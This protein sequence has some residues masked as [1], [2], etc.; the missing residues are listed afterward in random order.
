ME[1]PCLNDKEGIE[2]L[3]NFL[4]EKSYISDYEAT[5]NDVTVFKAL[6]SSK[7]PDEKYVN[8]LRWYRHIKSLN[9]QDL[10]V[11]ATVIKIPASTIE[12]E[13]SSAAPS[14]VFVV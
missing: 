1:F 11:A 13:V 9:R 7:E 3:E 5:Q 14:F 6:G 8:I 10:P 4:A 12:N 2:F